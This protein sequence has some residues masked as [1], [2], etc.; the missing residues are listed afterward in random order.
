MRSEL[1]AVAVIGA[2]TIV[3]AVL[4]LVLG[5]ARVCDLSWAWVMSP[6][7]ISVC[8][9]AVITLLALGIPLFAILFDKPQ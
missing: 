9:V 1:K 7:L 6:I 8:G 5:L 3:L 2:L 4:K